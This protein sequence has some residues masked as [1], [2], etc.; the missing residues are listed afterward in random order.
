MEEKTYF[1]TPERVTPEELTIQ[2]DHVSQNSIVSG[3]LQSVNGILAIVNNKRQVVAVNSTFLEMLNIEDCDELL[4]LRPG[5]IL[6]CTFAEDDPAGCGTTKQCATCGAAIAMVACL[7]DGKPVEKTC[8]V[9]VVRGNRE[10]DI[11]LSVRAHPLKINSSTFLLLF[12]QDI[13]RQQ[14]RA[15]LERTFFHD[16]NNL[17]SMLVGASE[18]LL[19]E[20]GT[21]LAQDVHT[22]AT[23]VQQEIVVQR[24]LFDGESDVYTP[25]WSTTRAGQVL[26][27]L[28]SFFTSH[29]AAKERFLD[30]EH[31]YENQPLQTD[32]TLINRILV[33]MV[34][35]ALEAIRPGETVRVWITRE[36]ESVCFH[37][38]NDSYIEEY[39]QKRIFH[40]N[41]SSKEGYGRG[42][43]TF[44]MKLLGEDILGGSVSFTSTREEGT[45]FTLALP[46]RTNT[47]T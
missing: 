35:N 11:A 12:L 17:L 22:S 29:P 2:I 10:S 30:I 45:I 44:S 28:P 39:I 32:L 40:R 24:C 4:G 14:Q 38:K 33:N 8:A 46:Q 31:S 6:N 43:G 34:T 42:V 47:M 19:E 7:S 18:L 23:R 20:S 41:F 27:D 15:S 16:I 3:L 25:M 13:T 5:E 21:Q 36:S 37:V 1:A 9:R 26:T